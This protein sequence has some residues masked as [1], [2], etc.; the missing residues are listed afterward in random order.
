[1]ETSH[2]IIDSYFKKLVLNSIITLSTS[3]YNE[4][5]DEKV[6][7]CE[8]IKIV[9]ILENKSM[10]AKALVLNINVEEVPY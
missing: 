1:M 6:L 8:L 4:K 5:E 7:D 9:K 3:F 2:E 10:E